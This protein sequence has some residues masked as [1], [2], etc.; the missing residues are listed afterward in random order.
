MSFLTVGINNGDHVEASCSMSFLTTGLAEA[1][2]STSLPTTGMTNGDLVAASCSTSVPTAGITSDDQVEASITSSGDLVEASCASNPRVH[3]VGKNRAP[4][5]SAAG[6]VGQV[7]EPT[8]WPLGRRDPTF[9]FS[10]TALAEAASTTPSNCDVGAFWKEMET[11]SAVALSRDWCPLEHPIVVDRT[12][13]CSIGLR[14]LESEG[15]LTKPRISLGALL[16]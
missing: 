8:T 1:S 3:V 11:Q 16:K 12:K 10:A 14:W 7:G 6:A 4:H 5:P 15:K 13:H 2:C 9:S